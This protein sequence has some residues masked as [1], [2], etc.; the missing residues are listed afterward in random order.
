MKLEWNTEAAMLMLVVRPAV[1]KV[2]SLLRENRAEEAR[3]TVGHDIVGPLMEYREK[4]LAKYENTPDNLKSAPNSRRMEEN[5]K[6]METALLLL[7]EEKDGKLFYRPVEEWNL[8]AVG[9]LVDE[10][11]RS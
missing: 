9:R 5:V 3:D 11:I 7:L 10:M 6:R 4:E 8:D 2:K 1:D